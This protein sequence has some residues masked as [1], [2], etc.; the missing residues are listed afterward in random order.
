MIWLAPLI[1]SLIS[2]SSGFIAGAVVVKKFF[3]RQLAVE[4]LKKEYVL[5]LESQEKFEKFVKNFTIDEWIKKQNREFEFIVKNNLNVL[6]ILYKD[7]MD[8]F[9]PELSLILINLLITLRGIGILKNKKTI[10]YNKEL[11]KKFIQ[12]LNY[13]YSERKTIQDILYNTELLGILLIDTG[14]AEIFDSELSL[15]TWYSSSDIRGEVVDFKIENLQIFKDQKLL[16]H[17]FIYKLIMV[18]SGQEKVSFIEFMKIYA[19]AVLWIFKYLIK[20]S[21]L[22]IISF[23]KEKKSFFENFIDNS[24]KYFNANYIIFPSDKMML[25]KFYNVF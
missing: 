17:P 4:E 1:I 9:S 19:N 13:N 23:E 14:S 3:D 6:N 12:I 5:F 21:F 24:D 7:S 22:S 15:R 10:K 8:V 11:I 25:E 18:K 2:G 20:Q 16:L